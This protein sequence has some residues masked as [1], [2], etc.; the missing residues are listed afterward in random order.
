M[1]IIT[2]MDCDGKSLSC[3]KKSYDKIYKQAA[4]QI[5]SANDHD[6]KDRVRKIEEESNQEKDVDE[7]K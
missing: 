3:D 1:T 5:I 4:N 7:E 6:I 2:W